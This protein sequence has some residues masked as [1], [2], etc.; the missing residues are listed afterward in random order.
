MGVL[1]LTSSLS[2]EAEHES[3]EDEVPDMPL[4]VDGA[5]GAESLL[6]PAVGSGETQPPGE[7]TTREPG[8]APVEAAA[9]APL[10]RIVSDRQTD[11]LFLS[12]IEHYKSQCSILDVS[13]TDKQTDRFF[14]FMH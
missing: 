5:E 14:F 4:Q 6:T 9:E 13:I 10:V 12:N 7:E 1:A 8:A 2:L 11:C 3:D